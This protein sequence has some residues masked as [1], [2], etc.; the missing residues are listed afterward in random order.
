MNLMPNL[1][2]IDPSLQEL[3]LS[4][5]GNF[6]PCALS[7]GISF[8]TA[9]LTPRPDALF[10][11]PITFQYLTSPSLADSCVADIGRVLPI[12]NHWDCARTR[13]VQKRE[14]RRA[15]IRL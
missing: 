13:E 8:I 10:P 12:R 15:G 1:T 5:V 3:L 9:I 6:S 11:S 14:V 7:S 4:T 2:G